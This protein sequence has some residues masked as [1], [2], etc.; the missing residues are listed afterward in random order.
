MKRGLKTLATIASVAPWLGLLITVIG[1][2]GSFVGCGG[3]KSTCMA[4]IVDRLANVIA[5]SALG[6]LVG[7]IAL[8][9][10]I[11]IS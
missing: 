2:V 6:L 7:I 8:S 10:S 4:A 5:R 9:F 3:E 1:I 11:G